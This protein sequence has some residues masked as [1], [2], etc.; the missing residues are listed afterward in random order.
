MG[1]TEIRAKLLKRP[2]LFAAVVVV[3]AAL[4]LLC[5][6]TVLIQ[7][8]IIAPRG[9]KKTEVQPSS[10]NTAHAIPPEA[11]FIPDEPDFVP[12]FLVE[13][14]VRGSWSLDEIRPY[15]RA[16]TDNEFLRRI[17]RSAVDDL[18]TGVR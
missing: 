16:Q 14:E 9:S 4:V 11:L 15:W 13:R 1:L 2:L 12:P 6:M 7:F 10:F 18:M 5:I 3:L 8:G 17:V